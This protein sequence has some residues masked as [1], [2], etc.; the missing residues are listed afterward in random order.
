L[1]NANSQNANLKVGTAL[2][3]AKATEQGW[4]GRA[5]LEYDS[6]IQGCEQ[7]FDFF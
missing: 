2:A 4:P 7:N 3:V 1:Q 5:I 6:W